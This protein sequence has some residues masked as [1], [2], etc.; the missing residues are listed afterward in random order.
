MALAASEKWIR[1]TQKLSKV[2]VCVWGVSFSVQN[3]HSEIELRH[4]VD[5]EGTLKAMF[6]RLKAVCLISLETLERK[7]TL[8][9]KKGHP[10]VR[11]PEQAMTKANTGH[12]PQFCTGHGTLGTA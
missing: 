3:S 4:F 9:T 2:C 11:F 7:G 8:R 5:E 10:Q 1:S 6:G 12:S